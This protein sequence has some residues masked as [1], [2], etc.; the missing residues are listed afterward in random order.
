MAQYKG[1]CGID[2]WEVTRKRL[3]MNRAVM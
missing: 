2:H 1:R 3:T